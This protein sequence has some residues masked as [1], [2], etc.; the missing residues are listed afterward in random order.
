MTTHI[1]IAELRRLLAAAVN[2]LG[3]LLDELE[4]ARETIETQKESAAASEIVLLR[5]ALEEIRSRA[6]FFYY[7]LGPR[8]DDRFLEIEDRARVTLEEEP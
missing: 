4:A 2:S 8:G 6:H 7:H 1:D 3:P 5:S